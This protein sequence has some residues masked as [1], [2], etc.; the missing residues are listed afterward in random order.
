MKECQNMLTQYSNE[1]LYPSIVSVQSMTDVES[2]FCRIRNDNQFFRD[3]M[4]ESKKATKQ[5]GLVF[6]FT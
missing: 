6:V 3:L 4:F 1:N 2:K 5:G